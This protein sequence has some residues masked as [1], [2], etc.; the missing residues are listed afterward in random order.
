MLLAETQKDS[1]WVVREWDRLKKKYGNKFIAV[2]GCKVIAHHED[3][4]SLMKIVDN[5]VP[6]KKNFVTTEFIGLK[7]LRWVK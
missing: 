1:E 3:I 2:L 7:E 4:K 5:K 6:Q